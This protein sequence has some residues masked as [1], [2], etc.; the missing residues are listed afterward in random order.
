MP[1]TAAV[2]CSAILPAGMH[3]QHMRL[4]FQAQ[5][6]VTCHQ[7]SLLACVSCASCSVV[8]QTILMHFLQSLHMSSAACGE[9]HQLP[10]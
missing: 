4:R 7:S 8:Q 9:Q 3:A 2:L 6:S 5:A 1:G 10:A